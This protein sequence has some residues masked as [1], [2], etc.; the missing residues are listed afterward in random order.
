MAKKGSVKNQ[1]LVL[2]WYSTGNPGRAMKATCQQLF[3]Q[4][5]VRIWERGGKAWGK[6]EGVNKVSRDSD[7]ETRVLHF[8][9]GVSGGDK[10]HRRERKGSEDQEGELASQI[11][12]SKQR[13][14]T[15]SAN[16]AISPGSALKKLTGN[17]KA[18]RK[19]KKTNALCMAKGPASEKSQF[20]T[21]LLEN[22]Q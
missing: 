22:L 13:E 15:I 16:T 19:R 1:K 7:W 21:L 5:R 11:S 9:A 20:S 18:R 17:A 6:H 8:H 3:G 4:R 10:K 2:R 14:K 12:D